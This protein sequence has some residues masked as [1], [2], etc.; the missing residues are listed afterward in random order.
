MLDTAGYEPEV[1]AGSGSVRL[2]NCP[3]HVLAARHRD[4]TCGM[5]L[6]WAEGVVGGLVDPKLTLELAPT[7][8]YCCVVFND[9]PSRPNE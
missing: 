8:G 5:N 6:A 1:D 4:L 2:R 7:P 3:F 9:D